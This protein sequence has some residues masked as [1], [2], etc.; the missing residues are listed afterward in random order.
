MKFLR[1]VVD[2]NEQ[3]IIKKQVLDEIIFIESFFVGHQKILDLECCQF[4]YH[5]HVIAAAFCKQDVLKLMFIKYFK[6]LIT[7]N[8]LLSAGESTNASME[9]SYSSACSN[10]EART[11]PSTSQTHRSILVISFSPSIFD[12]KI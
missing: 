3:K 1:P 4:A 12:C 7:G 6:E 11:F 2:I 10:V 5:I 9:L 8:H